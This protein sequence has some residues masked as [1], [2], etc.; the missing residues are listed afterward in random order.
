MKRLSTLG[1]AAWLAIAPAHAPAQQ[2][3]RAPARVL[4]QTLIVVADDF[5]VDVYHN[6]VKVPDDRRELIHE[7]HGATV[8]RLRIQVR[9][10][11]W[12]VFNVVNNRMRWGGASYFA[13]AGQ[14]DSGV[15]FTTELDSGHWSCCDDLG[16]VGQFIADRERFADHRAMPIS[17]PWG[18]GDALMNH[19]A[20]GWGGKPLWAARRTPGSSS[21]PDDR[22]GGYLERV[23]NLTGLFSGFP[24]N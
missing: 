5:L 17:K 7:V 3:T 2:P 6:G 4:A 15:A 22:R 24:R 9:P 13:V 12:L 11:D 19:H 20:D 8:E 14:G 23:M 16:Q 1:L 10:G 18:E 21:S